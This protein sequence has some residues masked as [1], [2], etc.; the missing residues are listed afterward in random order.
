MSLCACVQRVLRVGKAAAT[1]VPRA[2]AENAG[3]SRCSAVP[4]ATKKCASGARVSPAS[5]PARACANPRS[6][7]VLVPLLVALALT[8]PARALEPGSPEDVLIRYL[9]ALKDGKP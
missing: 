9:R 4:P 5:A 2:H 6:M 7:R 1:D 3:I 8:L